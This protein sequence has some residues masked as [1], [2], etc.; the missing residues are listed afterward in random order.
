MV[1]LAEVVAT[2]GYSVLKLNLWRPADDA[3]RRAA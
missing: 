2:I 3:Q 1:L